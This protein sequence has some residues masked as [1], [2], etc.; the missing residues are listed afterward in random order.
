MSKQPPKSDPKIANEP[1]EP[2]PKLAEL[3]ALNLRL[4]EVK[5]GVSNSVAVL[6]ALSE[7]SVQR[8]ELAKKLATTVLSRGPEIVKSLNELS[9]D[10][11]KLLEKP[12]DRVG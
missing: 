2:S 1:P 8:P 9:T 5:H 11:Q 7:M 6:M 4:R 12:G 10:F 3:E